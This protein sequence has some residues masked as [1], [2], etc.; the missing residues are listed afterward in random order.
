MAQGIWICSYSK[1]GQAIL[2]S[3][4]I[5]CVVTKEHKQNNSFVPKF[6]AENNKTLFDSGE[7][8]R[9]A[10]VARVKRESSIE[11]Q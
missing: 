2:T 8:Y 1:K 4:S 3:H 10:D 9:N 7:N 11:Q 6:I 5:M